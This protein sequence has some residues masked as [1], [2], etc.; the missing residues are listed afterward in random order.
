MVIQKSALQG[1]D[2]RKDYTKVTT[3]PGGPQHLD[4]LLV[5]LND[6]K[7]IKKYCRMQVGAC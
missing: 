3:T 1:R 4:D 5:L 7:D 2:G 6:C